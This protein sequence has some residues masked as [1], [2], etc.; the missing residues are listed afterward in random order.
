[1]RAADDSRNVIIDDVISGSRSD[2]IGLARGDIIV[3]V[4]GNEVH[5]TRELNDQL[6]RSSDRSS[7]VLSVARG[8]Y[9][10]NLTFPMGV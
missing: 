10:Y 5:S 6:M 8:R 7:I 9:V 4:N 3:G 1:L 2:Q